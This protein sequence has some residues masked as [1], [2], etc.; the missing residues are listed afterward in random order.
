MSSEFSHIMDSVVEAVQ[1]YQSEVDR[2]HTELSQQVRVMH[3]YSADFTNKIV[4][5]W[6]QI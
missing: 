6:L 4:Q 5:G 1:V 2:F 3:V